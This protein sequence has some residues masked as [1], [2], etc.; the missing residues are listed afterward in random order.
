M[1]LMVYI[2]YDLTVSPLETEPWT[3]QLEIKM[4]FLI[5][6]LS[7]KLIGASAGDTQ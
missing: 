3:M 1:V 6:S 4:T 5:L 2:E 7:S